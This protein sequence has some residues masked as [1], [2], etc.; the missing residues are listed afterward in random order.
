MAT[1]WQRLASVTAGGSTTT[2][3]TGTITAKKHLHVEVK[4]VAASGDSNEV[5]FNTDTGSNYS[6]R[7][8]DDGGSDGTSYTSASAAIIGDTANH[9]C[10]CVTDI[11]NILDKEKLFISHSMRRMATGAGN[12][13]QRQEIV[14]KWANT[15]AQITNI[16]YKAE[17]Q[18]I[19][20]GTVM[21]VW[22]ADDQ[23]STPFYPN[24]PNGAIFEDTT[25][26]NHYMWN[27]T[28]TWN[29]VT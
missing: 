12:A 14:G 20:S 13:P 28:D 23:P 18:T 27:G 11:S 10:L 5:Y 22:G 25:D 4:V 2:I 17:G 26:G 8:S 3:T 9:D 21:T 6:M 16:T 7:L 1:S 24:I 15:S 29:E 19:S